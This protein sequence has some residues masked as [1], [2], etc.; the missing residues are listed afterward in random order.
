MFTY[1]NGN[2][3][4]TIT[5]DGVKTRETFIE[6]DKFNPEFPEQSDIKI[7][8][9]CDLSRFGGN[10]QFCHENSNPNGKHANLELLLEKFR[11]LPNGYEI[12]AGGGEVFAHQ[13]FIDF[14]KEIKRRNLIGNATVN[15]LHLNI[16]KKELE[17]CLSEKL[18]NGLGVSYRAENSNHD[19]LY[20]ISKYRFSIIHVIAGIDSVEDVSELVEKLHTKNILILGYKDFRRG[21]AFHAR[22]PSVDKNIAMWY[23]QLPVFVAKVNSL[24]GIVSFDNL[25]IKQLNVRRILSEEQ[26]NSFYQGEDGLQSASMY[27]DAVEQKFA[28]NSCAEERFDYK[29][30]I[31]EMFEFLKEK[32]N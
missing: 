3:Q 30:T 4:V 11:G 16:R 29:E 12:A 13:G 10:C 31:I 25:A 21:A 32:Y 18:I 27:I 8:N 22:H 5:D 24:G 1:K 17:Y 19:A 26:W 7:T 9:K 15:E 20:E 23:N 14:L 6:T 2:Y 28:L